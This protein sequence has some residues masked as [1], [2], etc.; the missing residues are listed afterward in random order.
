MRI[1]HHICLRPELFTGFLMIDSFGTAPYM[2]TDCY[3]FVGDA[4]REI[5]PLAERMPALGPRSDDASKTHLS[6]QTQNL[7]AFITTVTDE[8]PYPRVYR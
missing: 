2:D 6:K 4:I 7:I 1:Q 3:F 5:K 8:A